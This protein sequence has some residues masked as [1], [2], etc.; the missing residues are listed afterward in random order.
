[1]ADVAG[2]IKETEFVGTLNHVDL[3]VKN[4]VNFTDGKA[5][6]F[7]WLKLSWPLCCKK[8]PHTSSVTLLSIHLTRYN[9]NNLAQDHDL[10]KYLTV[11]L[12]IYT[13]LK[14]KFVNNN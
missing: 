2:N 14:Y 3:S 8:Q 1:M 5:G 13:V 10:Q 6:P 12:A 9:Q 7:G 11:Q 4:T